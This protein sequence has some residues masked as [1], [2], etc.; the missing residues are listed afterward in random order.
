MRK[1]SLAVLLL[2]LS[3][4]WAWSQTVVLRPETFMLQVLQG[5]PLA[6]QAKLIPDFAQTSVLKARGGFDPKLSCDLSQKY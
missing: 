5:H 6:Q 3:A 2:V 1:N 4:S